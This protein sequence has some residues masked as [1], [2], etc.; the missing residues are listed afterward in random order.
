MSEWTTCAPG[1]QVEAAA[2][3]ARSEEASTQHAPAEVQ[4]DPLP[5][6]TTIWIDVT[7]FV[8]SLPE[9]DDL[10]E[11]VRNALRQADADIRNGGT[12][13]TSEL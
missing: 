12:I 11:D 3:Q 2:P 7:S 10:D 1:A 8:I 9:E 4:G 6:T 5:G 13:P